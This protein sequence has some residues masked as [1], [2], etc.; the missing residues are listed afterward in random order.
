MISD[1]MSDRK[2]S[3][4]GSWIMRTLAI[5]FFLVVDRWLTE[6][7]S[8][9]GARSNQNKDIYDRTFKRTSALFSYRVVVFVSSQPYRKPHDDAQYLHSSVH[10]LRILA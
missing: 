3:V 5:R 7:I 4:V 2:I 6:R 10:F 1:F 9:C 8:R